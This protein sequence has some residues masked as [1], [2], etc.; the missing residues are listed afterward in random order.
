MSFSQSGQMVS[1]ISERMMRLLLNI[2]GHN[3]GVAAP[4][5]LPA[6]S[7][8]VP[9]ARLIL[10]STV[11]TLPLFQEQM[12]AAAQATES[13][14]LLMRHGLFPETLEPTMCDLV[15]YLNGC[16]AFI[17]DMLLYHHPVDGFWLVPA[18]VGP[19]VAI[20][21]DGLRVAE[22]PPYYGTQER[23]D[24]LCRAARLIVQHARRPGGH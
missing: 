3:A 23:S 4:G 16:P 2:S 17:R 11:C 19:H 5:G 20:E 13:D 22:E 21:H 18:G 1:R 14:V 6:G 12:L 9:D 7:V 15:L 8:H 10:A 24:A